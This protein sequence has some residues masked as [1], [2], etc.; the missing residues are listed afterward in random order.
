MRTIKFLLQ[1]EFLQIFRDKMLLL[2]ILL[3]PLM[4]LI[5]LPL[6]ANYTIKGI[7]IAFVDQDYSTYSKKLASKILSSGYFKSAGYETSYKNALKLIE[8]DKADIILQIP[9]GFERN[10]VREGK[11]EI[12]LAVNA[13]NG[14]KALLGG[15]YLNKIIS[16]FNAEIR[17]RW[18][19]PSRFN[20]AP[21]IE[22]E[23]SNWFNPFMSYFILMVPGFLVSLL[24]NVGGFLAALNI[25]KE[26]EAGTIEQ[27]NVSPIKK[28]HFV[29]GKLLPFWILGVLEFTIGLIIAR[30][31]YG[32]IPVGSI[33]LLYVFLAV[34]LVALLG[35]GLLI[36]TYADTQQQAISI[37][38]F[39]IM[40]FIF[41]SGLYSPLVSIPFWAK[42]ISEINPL[43]HFIEVIRM[44][45]LKGSTFSDVLYHFGFI[46]ILAIVFNVWAIF[47]YKKTV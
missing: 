46:I 7:K 25:V 6:V 10:L 35:L 5:I 33:L 40:V 29:I 39:V 19:Q 47:N 16:N 13:I 22:V 45:M 41:L 32:I 34:Y 38:Y 8:E 1:K 30:Y 27:L 37:A 12:Y 23:T 2:I 42:I 18:Q 9:Q 4:Q 17:L 31:V 24:T 20:Q 28:S 43:T 26:K 36:S 14:V 44:V 21:V 3:G 15:S 11:Q